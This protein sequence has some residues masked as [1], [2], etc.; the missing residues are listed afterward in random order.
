MCESIKKCGKADASAAL[1]LSLPAAVP[2]Y[3]VLNMSY[4]LRPLT[5]NDKI[6][7]KLPR[8]GLNTKYFCCLFTI[9]ANIF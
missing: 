3:K 6:V 5:K 8:A 1:R 9:T 4:V 7:A 2:V